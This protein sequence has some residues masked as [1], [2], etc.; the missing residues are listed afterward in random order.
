MYGKMIKCPHC[1]RYINVVLTE[2]Q[3]EILRVVKDRKL[4]ITDIKEHLQLSY[5][6]TWNNIRKLEKLELVKT[7]KVISGL[8]GS[9]VFITKTQQ[10]RQDLT[11]SI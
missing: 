7:Q 6:N 11:I 2:N 4:C 10:L 3:K 8:R 5:R 1:N 9:P